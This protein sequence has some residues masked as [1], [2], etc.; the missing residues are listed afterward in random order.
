MSDYCITQDELI[1]FGTK[2]GDCC[3]SVMNTRDQKV[4]LE[5]HNAKGDHCSIT[6]TPPQA[7]DLAEWINAC[8][9][10]AVGL[11]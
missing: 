8:A 6:M 3:I 10:K 1:K 2:H 7:A 4:F 11:R 5:M 9:Q